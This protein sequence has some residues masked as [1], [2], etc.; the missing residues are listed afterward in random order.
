MDGEPVYVYDDGD[1][2]SNIV[3]D[4]LTIIDSDGAESETIDSA[5]WVDSSA[6]DTFD[7]S[8][9]TRAIQKIFEADFWLTFRAWES[10]SM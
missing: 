4:D 7:S 8:E 3:I 1:I 10:E 9:A 2:V 6:P 5:I